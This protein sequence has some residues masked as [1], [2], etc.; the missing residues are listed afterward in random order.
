MAFCIDYTERKGVL[1]K[2]GIEQQRLLQQIL[3]QLHPFRD[4]PQDGHG[5]ELSTLLI[6]NPVG[7]CFRGESPAILI[8]ELNQLEQGRESATLPVL[9]GFTPVELICQAVNGFAEQLLFPITE[10]SF[11]PQACLGY[12]ALLVGKH[13]RIGNRAQR[14]FEVALRASRPFL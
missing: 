5:T 7:Q 3:L 1:A 14:R 4:I 10:N 9:R 6:L 13:R 2:N 11:G 8:V 12:T